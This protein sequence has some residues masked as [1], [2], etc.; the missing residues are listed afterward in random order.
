MGTHKK[1]LI[2]EVRKLQEKLVRMQSEIAGLQADLAQTSALVAALHESI[3][4]AFD[5][6]LATPAENAK[7]VEPAPQADKIQAA[8]QPE[9]ASPKQS[10]AA[11]VDARRLTD[12]KKA[13][14][15]NDR[16]RFR[17]D[18]FANDDELMMRTIDE[19]NR[20]DNFDEAMNYIKSRFD[21]DIEDPTVTYLIDIL[22]RRF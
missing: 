7:S 1:I 4:D 14:G 9:I 15:L 19:L 22:H 17:H 20:L 11:P 12:I 6:E 2:A 21:W 10:A 13:M 16:F 18:L 5:N 3:A 8:K